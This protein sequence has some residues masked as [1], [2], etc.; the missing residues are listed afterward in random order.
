VTL[1]EINAVGMGSW[2]LGMFPPGRRM[3][4]ADAAVAMDN[5][6][7]AHVLGYEAVHRARP[8]AI[9]TTN[10][11]SVTLYE[12]DALLTDVL[13]ARSMGIDRDGLDRW[14]DE[15]R[16]RHYAAHPTSN[17]GEQAL[18]RFSAAT[19]PY[20]LRSPRAGDAHGSRLRPRSTGRAVD[21]VYASTHERT[22][23]VV[24]FDY[25]DPL[26]ARHIRLP[27]H[28]T[29]GGRAWAPARELWDDVPDPEGLHTWL[30]AQHAMTPDVSLWVVENGLCNRVRN[31]RSYPRLDG[32]DRSRYIRENIAAVVAA[33]DAG[34][35]VGGYWHWSL[36]DNYEWGSYQPRF[37]LF[38]LD[39]HHGPTGAQWLDTDSLGGDAAG[40]YR[41]IIAGLRDGDRSV[42]AGPT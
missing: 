41:R 13:M 1:N 42:L 29:A 9:V 4:F 34:L 15:R 2:I 10:N 6:L 16:I 22:L 24:G 18:R 26:A 5:M 11:A 27:G 12:F 32:W 14:L 7:A 28:V 19:S 40:T 38:G 37:G 31:G 3:A 35:P 39:R 20:G 23:D 25:Y 8:D 30:R 36:V 17:R 33:A 21:V